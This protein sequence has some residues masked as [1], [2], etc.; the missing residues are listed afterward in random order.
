MSMRRTLLPL[1]LVALLGISQSQ[2]DTFAMGGMAYGGYSDMQSFHISAGKD[3]MG[4]TVSR[5]IDYSTVDREVIQASLPTSDFTLIESDVR[6]NAS[7]M[8]GFDY[9]Q[10]VSQNLSLTLGL[11]LVVSENCDLYR[12]DN[13]GRYYCASET[14]SSR[15]ETSAGIWQAIGQAYFGAGY[16]LTRGP[17]LSIGG[18][19]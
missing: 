9:Y 4:L 11:G 5:I 3:Q 8:V 16:S 10:P 7:I 19:L 17:Y 2:A 13:T 15:F 6:L 1:L 12:S 14:R 18:S